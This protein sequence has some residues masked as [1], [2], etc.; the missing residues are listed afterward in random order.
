MPYIRLGVFP[1]TQTQG[2]AAKAEGVSL[3]LEE[4]GDGMPCC[5]LVQREAAFHNKALQLDAHQG[6]SS[7]YV[8][9]PG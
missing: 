2:G 1:H 3:Q 6:I 9:F 7:L 5:C 4:R 8:S